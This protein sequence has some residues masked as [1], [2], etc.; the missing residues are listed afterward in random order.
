MESSVVRSGWLLWR[1]EC[2]I[3]VLSRYNTFRLSVN[4]KA[5]SLG[6]CVLMILSV[7]CMAII[8]AHSIF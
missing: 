2:L 5:G 4:I 6:N 3:C 7:L 1:L 8:S